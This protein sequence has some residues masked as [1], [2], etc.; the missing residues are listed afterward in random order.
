VNTGLVSAVDFAPT[1][2]G[3]VGMDPSEAQSRY[4]AMRG[5]DVSGELTSSSTERS[6]SGGG[7]LVTYSVSH[8]ND[9][10]FAATALRNRTTSSGM[11]RLRNSLHTGLFPDFKARSF[12]RGIV[13]DDFKFARYFSPREHHKPET[14]DEITS[15][16]DLELFDLR[17][18]LGET[19]N[20]AVGNELS[21][22]VLTTLNSKLNAL[23]DAEGGQ[24]D[25]RDMPGPHFYWRG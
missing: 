4:A 18:D 16:N 24:D 13:T 9:P 12:M 19:R 2:L 3:L 10:E 8:H 5:T 15:R 11:E 20:L 7:A 14:I 17:G 23:L 1:M 21:T 25:G 6:R 22:D